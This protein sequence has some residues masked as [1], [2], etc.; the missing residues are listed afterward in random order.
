[1][2]GTAGRAD[3]L[4]AAV[5]AQKAEGVLHVHMFVYLQ[6]ASQ[7]HTLYELANLFR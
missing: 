7:F 6:M 5:E 4:F 2:G 1:M 3:A